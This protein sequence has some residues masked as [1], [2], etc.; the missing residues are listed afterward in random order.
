MNGIHLTFANSRLNGRLPYVIADE[1]LMHRR[2][3]GI[4]SWDTWLPKHLGERSCYLMGLR[5]SNAA[6]V[7]GEST[8]RLQVPKEVPAY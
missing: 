2:A 7:D 5:Y 1:L 4:Y 8:Y 3:G 6:L